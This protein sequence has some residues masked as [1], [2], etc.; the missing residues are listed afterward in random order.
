MGERGNDGMYIESRQRSSIAVPG[1]DAGDG[2][3]EL[4]LILGERPS[5]GLG[6]VLGSDTLECMDLEEDRE[7]EDCHARSV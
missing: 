3:A 4:W 6:S 5:S 2:P 7:W 1:G